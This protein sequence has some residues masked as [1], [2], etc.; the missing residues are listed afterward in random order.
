MFIDEIPSVIKSKNTNDDIEI[1]IP[2]QKLIKWFIPNPM[3]NLTDC[4]DDL[5][6]KNLDRERFFNI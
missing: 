4:L 2:F 5:K 6:L 3:A 1:K